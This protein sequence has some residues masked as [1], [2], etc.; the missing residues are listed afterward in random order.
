MRPS[1]PRAPAPPL[2]SLA[3]VAALSCTVT[4][5]PA[6]YENRS[7]LA[8]RCNDP[9]AIASLPASLQ[10][11][12]SVDTTH[13]TDNYRDFAACVGNDLPGNDGFYAITMHPGETW[14]FHVDPVVGA[15]P[16]LYILPDCSEQQCSVA[17]ASDMCGVGRGE[18]F[19]FRPTMDGVY[20]LGIDSRLPGGAVYALTA[21]RPVCGNGTLEHG[22]P[23]DDTRPQVGVT[24]SRCHKV[25]AAPMETEEGVANDD[26]VNAMLLR[27]TAGFTNFPVVGTIA[28]C[29]MD[30]FTF[31]A[32]AGQTVRVTVTPRTGTTCPPN[33]SLTLL[34][35]DVAAPP[36]LTAYPSVASAAVTTM[37]DGCPTVTLSN[38]PAASTWFAQVTI[39][40]DPTMTFSYQLTTDVR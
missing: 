31:D 4:F 32:A 29:D 33:V 27:P 24:C 30:M 35:S 25:L 5:D 23:C 16:A 7:M 13:L 14:H 22:E 17:G 38:A 39:H 12:V 10:Q 40:P 36:A 15:D 9:A 18:H 19:S 1:A 8:D 11:L 28:G 34:R 3:A 6:L 37:T 26:Y 21:V 20:Y 2:A